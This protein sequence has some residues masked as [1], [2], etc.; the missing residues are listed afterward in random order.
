MLYLLW[1]DWIASRNLKGTEKEVLSIKKK[2]SL[3]RYLLHE[4]EHKLFWPNALGLLGL[5]VSNRPLG[6]ADFVAAKLFCKGKP[7]NVSFFSF[8]LIDWLI[9]GRAGLH[10]CSGFSLVEAS[11]VYSLVMVCGL[12]SSGS[13][14][15][16]HRLSSCGTCGIFWNQGL[17]P[18]LLHW[19]ADSWPLSHQGSPTMSVFNVSI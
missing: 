17:N 11:R 9:D 13:R 16:E 15:L 12:R 18:R 10:C 4:K 1:K 14:A 3:K 7:P 2:I 8:W 19:E 5:S 6:D